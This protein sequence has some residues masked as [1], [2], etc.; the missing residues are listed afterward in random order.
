M[1]TVLVV[2]DENDIVQLIRYN[3]EREGFRVESAA[4]GDGALLKATEV[5]PDVILLD[6]MLPGKDGY[7]VIKALNQNERTMDIPV[8]FLTAKS[9]EFDEVLG[10]ELGADDYIVKPISPRKLVSRIRA[11]LRR[12]EGVKSEENKS[13]DFGKVVIDRES[14]LVKIGGEQVFFPRKEFEILYYLASHEGKVI[15]RE[16]L[17][18]RIWGSDVY[19]GDRT[20]DVHIRKIREKLGD[21]AEM[22]ET[23]KGVGYKFKAE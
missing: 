5:R 22:I 2:D 18:S 8:I 3:L 4:T 20:V 10:L 9:A 23:I 7:E 14:Y 21:H 1:K 16:T 17:L 11:V 6:I 13:I 19:V 15:S 12:Y